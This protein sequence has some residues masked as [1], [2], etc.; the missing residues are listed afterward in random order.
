MTSFDYTVNNYFLAI[1]KP[2]RAD[3]SALSGLGVAFGTSRFL[4]S[5]VNGFTNLYFGW[6]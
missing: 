1:P 2:D 3:Q 4:A 6:P 5:R